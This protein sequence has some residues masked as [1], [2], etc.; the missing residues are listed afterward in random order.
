MILLVP[1]VAVIVMLIAMAAN[2]DV[3]KRA[4]ARK[5]AK[6]LLNEG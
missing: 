1:V 2:Y 3:D 6:A 5:E 4:A